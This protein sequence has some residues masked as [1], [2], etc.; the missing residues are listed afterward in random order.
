MIVKNTYADGRTSG[1]YVGSSWSHD[2]KNNVDVYYR[3][4]EE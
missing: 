4:K 2:D 1:K 3:Y